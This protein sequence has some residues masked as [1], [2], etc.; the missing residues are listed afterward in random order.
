MAICDVCNKEMNTADGCI[1]EK[2]LIYGKHYQR[3]KVV[4][5]VCP[6]CGAKRNNIHHFGCDM[7]IC[8]KCGSQLLMCNCEDVGI[9]ITE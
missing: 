7:E 8:P 5:E 2:L 6:D 4:Q 1:G 9:E 3:I